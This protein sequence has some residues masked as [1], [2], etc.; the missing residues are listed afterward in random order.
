MWA[1]EHS[2]IFLIATLVR[3]G[4]WLGG[5][6]SFSQHYYTARMLWLGS[7]VL[8]PIAAIDLLTVSS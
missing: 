1:R 6:P 7:L 2:G 8:L 5:L 4:L 3:A